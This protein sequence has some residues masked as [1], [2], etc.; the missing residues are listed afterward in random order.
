MAH[1][2]AQM[3]KYTMIFIFYRN[4]DQWLLLKKKEQWKITYKAKM[5]TIYCIILVSKRVPLS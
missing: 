1:A 5:I 2:T 4:I 3:Q